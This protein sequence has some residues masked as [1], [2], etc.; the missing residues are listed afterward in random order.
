MCHASKAEAVTAARTD[1][2]KLGRAVNAD[3]NYKPTDPR[4]IRHEHC[5]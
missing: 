3:P 1:L 5:M 4:L 2:A